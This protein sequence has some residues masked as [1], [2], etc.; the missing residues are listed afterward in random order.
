MGE[1]K[2]IEKKG[3][4]LAISLI[5]FLIMLFFL[6]Y[7]GGIVGLNLKLMC[8][9][10]CALLIV[11]GKFYGHTFGDLMGAASEK[12]K[13]CCA[14]FMILCGIG[15]LIAAYMMAG[16]APILTIWLTNFISDKFI[17][18][19]SFVLTALMSEMVGTSFGTL[20]TLGVVLLSCAQVLGV[21]MPM[22]AAAIVFGIIYGGFLS[23][24]NDGLS[25]I[26]ALYDCTPND[27][28]RMDLIPTMI[29]TVIAIIFFGAAGVMGHA[30]GASDTAS[31][32]ASFKAEVLAYFNPNPI[33]IIPLILAI[34]L[35]FLKVDIIIN[36][37]VS[38]TVG[39][40]IAVAIQ[41]FSP[42]TCF[43]ALYDGFSTENFFPGVEMSEG[44]NGLLNRGGIF[45]MA[46]SVLFYAFM[47]IMAAFL[48]EIGIFDS[49]REALVS[50]IKNIK[51][52]GV[53]NLVTGIVIGLINLVT[54]DGL[55]TAI[56]SK[57]IFWDLWRENGYHQAG[58][59]KYSQLWGNGLGQIVPWGFCATYFSNMLGVPK[60]Q[61]IPLCFC[62]VLVPILGCVLGFFGIGIEKLSEEELKKIE[63]EN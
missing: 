40:I 62:S 35:V 1:N 10:C 33:V 63:A 59:M 60:E 28:I 17:I 21:S 24:F 11:V 25:S 48:S 13:A 44:L 43:S 12:F 52:A 22:E 46:D 31:V 5:L 58:I 4:S 14:F 16:T 56:I 50:R 57:D 36:F 47:V 32:V 42:V 29:S 55:P 53:L 61:W 15:Y 9:C 3:P 20:G 30:G 18:V 34:V 37:F 54:L 8:L 6:G 39:F 7:L 19:V 26:P 45:S 23:P 51:N 27:M 38:G 49:I 41:G 2:V